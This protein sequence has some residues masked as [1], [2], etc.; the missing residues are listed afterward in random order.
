MAIASNRTKQETEVLYGLL[1]RREN[2]NIEGVSHLTGRYYDVSIR[3]KHY[4]AVVL[5]YSFEYYEK[6]YH[7]AE[8]Q[9][10][11]CV[12]MVHNTVLPCDCLNLQ[13]SNYANAYEL[14]EYIQDL[15]AQRKGKTGSRVLLGMYLLGVHSAV[16][17][18]ENLKPTTRKRY[19][20]K[21]KMLRKREKGKPVGKRPKFV[22]D[23]QLEDE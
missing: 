13:A 7:L 8:I 20:A 3:G 22:E 2:Y 16:D 17:L 23:E 21:A 15:E 4:I 5:F 10:D 11:L 6:R 19:Q 12:C 14:P 1:A 18:V 9:P